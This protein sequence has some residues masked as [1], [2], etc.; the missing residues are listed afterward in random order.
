MELRYK[1]GLTSCSAV[2][3]AKR[4]VPQGSVVVALLFIIY[5]ADTVKVTKYCKFH[6]YVDDVQIYLFF[7]P[8]ET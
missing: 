1:D 2:K 8:S 4:R 6:V 5:C 3:S 7:K